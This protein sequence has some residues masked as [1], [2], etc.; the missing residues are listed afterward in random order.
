MRSWGRVL[1]MKTRKLLKMVQEK[2]EKT[3]KK[4]KDTAENMNT[5]AG[6]GSRCGK[7]QND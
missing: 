6:D 4:G 3:L 1:Q 5:V 7:E 2:D